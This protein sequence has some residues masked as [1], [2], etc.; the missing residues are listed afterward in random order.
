MPARKSPTIK[1]N[2]APV[3][4]L[5]G[6]IVA[7]CMGYDWDEALT[8][9]RAV[10]GLN[11]ASKARSLGLVRE[12]SAKKKEPRPRSAASETVLLLGREVPAVRTPEGLRAA[13]DGRADSPESVDRYLRGRFGESYEAAADALRALARAV[14]R[15]DLES[16]AFSLYEDFR[17]AVPRGTKGW[18]AAGVFDVERVNDITER[19]SGKPQSKRTTRRVASPPSKRARKK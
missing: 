13:K 2:R 5:W 16:A 18:G 10:A 12:S 9:G 19:L 7:E 1:I 6:A 3:L 11:A 14:A 15:E 4:T 17:P 8:L